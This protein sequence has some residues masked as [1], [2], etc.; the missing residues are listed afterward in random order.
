MPGLLVLFSNLMMKTKHKNLIPKIPFVGRFAYATRALIPPLFLAL[1][2]GA[3]FVS[4]KCPYVYG[5]ST[6]KT[7]IKNESQITDDMI[8]DTFGDENIIAV[9]LPSHDYYKI[10]ESYRDDKGVSRHRVLYNIGS[11]NELFDLLPKEIK[12]GHCGCG[13]IK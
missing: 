10:M 13:T 6:L 1:A 12:N 2:I 7:P 4:S 8:R 11:R 9:N 5:Y 3:Y